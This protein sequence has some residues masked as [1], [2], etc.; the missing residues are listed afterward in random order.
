M[1][2]L[3]KSFA[4]AVVL[5]VALFQFATASVYSQL[6]FIKIVSP[7][8]DQ[9]IKRGQKLKVKYV[10]QP[11]IQDNHA[12][13]RAASLDINFHSR[14]G[15][16]KQQ[17][18]AI[19]HKSC[20]VAAKDNKYVTYTKQWT[21]PKNTKPGS[22]AVDFIEVVQGRRGRFTATETVKVNVVD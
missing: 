22:Y 13:G 12:A 8:N 20:P 21:I 16:K 14:T 6:Q 19:I 7:K 4:V 17:Q 2:V 18:L 9:D 1:L 10:M 15:N 5:L 11:L 3:S